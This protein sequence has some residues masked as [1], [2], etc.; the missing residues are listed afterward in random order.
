MQALCQID[1]AQ[2]AVKYVDNAFNYAINNE[3]EN[4]RANFLSDGVQ[5]SNARKLNTGAFN[6]SSIIAGSI[7]TCPAR[8]R[9]EAVVRVEA[10]FPAA[11]QCNGCISVR[12]RATRQQALSHQSKKSSYIECNQLKRLDVCVRPLVY[13]RNKPPIPPTAKADAWIPFSPITVVS[14]FSENRRNYES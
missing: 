8:A 13:Q 3:R 12:R 5:K 10:A 1:Y 6:W 2:I 14:F 4:F 7:D 9:I 11:S